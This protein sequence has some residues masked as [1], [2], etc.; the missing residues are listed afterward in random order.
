MT[1]TAPW[2]FLG[3]RALERLDTTDA[4]RACHHTAHADPRAEGRPAL[5]AGR[6]A[7]ATRKRTTKKATE[8]PSRIA[9]RLEAAAE[10]DRVVQAAARLR[11]YRERE[12]HEAASPLALAVWMSRRQWKPIE[13][14]LAD[15]EAVWRAHPDLVLLAGLNDAH[16]GEPGR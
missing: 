16:P 5:S 13:P 9:K 1:A 12:G 10:L 2:Q 7:G 3:A 6:G 11:L 14:T 4:P 8:K 15:H